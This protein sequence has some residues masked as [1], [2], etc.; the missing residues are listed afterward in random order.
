MG[1]LQLRE[2]KELA[3]CHPAR[4]WWHWDLNSSKGIENLGSGLYEMS[5]GV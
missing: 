3:Q 2:V 5:V 1:S 4:K